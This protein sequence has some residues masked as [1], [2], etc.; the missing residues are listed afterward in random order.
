MRVITSLVASTQQ[1]PYTL[2][3]LLTTLPLCLEMLREKVFSFTQNKSL[4]G[5]R[6]EALIC[7]YLICSAS[8]E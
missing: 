6:D 3:A 8:C 4:A 2:V 7:L 1:M 5:S